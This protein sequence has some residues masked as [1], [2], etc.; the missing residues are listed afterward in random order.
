MFNI[1]VSLQSLLFGYF[2]GL[3]KDASMFKMQNG[4]WEAENSENP[5]ISASVNPK[6]CSFP[7]CIKANIH[8]IPPGA[9]RVCAVAMGCNGVIHR[10]AVGQGAFV[11]LAPC[12]RAVGLM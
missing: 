5:S 9:D 4:L 12:L 2:V 8:K 3:G 7:S 6:C 10:N 11:S 1:S